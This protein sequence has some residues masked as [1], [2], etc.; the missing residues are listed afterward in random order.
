MPI[1]ASNSTNKLVA[2][3]NMQVAPEGLVAAAAAAE[4]EAAAASLGAVGGNGSVAAAPWL[5]PVFKLVRDLLQE[6]EPTSVRTQTTRSNTWPQGSRLHAPNP[7]TYV[8]L[9]P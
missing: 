1:H 7:T 4:S 8:Y 9:L 3:D 2:H 5:E 6:N